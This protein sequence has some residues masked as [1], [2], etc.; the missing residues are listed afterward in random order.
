MKCSSTQK[1]HLVVATNIAE[2]D[3]DASAYTL[4]N[5]SCTH[6]KPYVVAIQINGAELPT[7]VDTGTALIFISKATFD[8]LWDAQGAPNL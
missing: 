6:S 5:A 4:F 3:T 7:E 1:T 8:R 2:N